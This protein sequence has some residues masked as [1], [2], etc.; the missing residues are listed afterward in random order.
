[1]RHSFELV[2]NGGGAVKGNL[3]GKTADQN[4]WNVGVAVP[5]GPHTI[6]A[7]YIRLKDK[8]ATSADYRQLGVSY[9]YA[10]SKRT[11]LYASYAKGDNDSGAAYTLQGASS[12][13]IYPTVG[14]DPSSLMLGMRHRF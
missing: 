13:D 7:Q 8:V 14:Y 5:F 10:L 4:A 1:M 6:T 9:E 12:N 11:N 2:A 3:T